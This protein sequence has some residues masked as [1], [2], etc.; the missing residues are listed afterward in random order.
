MPKKYQSKYNLTNKYNKI[1]M[2]INFLPLPLNLSKTTNQYN[3]INLKFRKNMFLR[4]H[5]PRKEKIKIVSIT[6]IKEIVKMDKPL[7]LN[8][9]LSINISGK[10]DSSVS[11]LCRSSIK[12]EKNLEKSQVIAL[13]T[14]MSGISTGNS[15]HRKLV[16][17]RLS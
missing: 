8:F 9:L 10:M 15:S 3:N 11:K 7:H 13:S 6:K 4:D 5:H 14:V 17:F 16:N 1:L 2:N 12:A